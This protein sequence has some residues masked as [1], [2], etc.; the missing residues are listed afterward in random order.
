MALF[1]NILLDRDGTVI[2][3]RHYLSDP[4]GVT[5]F[6]GAGQALAALAAA[7]C[8]LFLVTNQSGIGR[9]YFTLAD[10]DACQQRLADLLA[11]FGVA[12]T[13]VVYCPHGPEADCH[14]RKPRT[15][16][17][18]TLRQRHG[19]DPA[20]TVIIGDKRD[21]IGVATGASLGAG[22]LVLTGKGADHASK[23]G[24]CP[25]VSPASS[26]SVSPSASVST[27][28]LGS[29]V[30]SQA[31]APNVSPA[32]GPDVRPAM[33]TDVSPPIRMDTR[34]AMRTDA[35]S[36]ASQGGNSGIPAGDVAV[37][38]TDV[39]GCL[40]SFG[41]CEVPADVASPHGP[42]PH[43]VARDL[44][45]AAHWILTRNGDNA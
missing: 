7:G 42:R 4:A 35:S 18:E 11:P 23:M 16:M 9:G 17:W 27:S 25:S 8:R 6:P 28:P 20:E 5:L 13:D 22:I 32:A 15:G 21:D 31:A 40:N 33:R 38:C 1:R 43:V 2:E 14:C 41:W 29:P 44:A 3:D 10:L 34:P 26:P 24:V 37:A 39:C 30:F 12:F 45:A 19:L 36:S